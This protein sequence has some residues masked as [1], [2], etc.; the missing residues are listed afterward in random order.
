M[1]TLIDLP[2]LPAPDC[3]PGRRE[4]EIPECPAPDHRR[5]I[6]GYKRNGRT[7]ICPTVLEYVRAW[8]AV[9]AAKA[10]VRRARRQAARQASRPPRRRLGGEIEVLFDLA[11]ADDLIVA[12]VLAG[13]RYPR[14]ELTRGVYGLD[15]HTTAEIVRRMVNAHHSDRVIA[16]RVGLEIRSVTRYVRTLRAM[17]LVPPAG[18]RVVHLP[19]WDTGK[20][21]SAS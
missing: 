15:K 13:A 8:S 1:G 5:S 17:G 14:Q 19:N 7:C 16:E 12:A 10:R 9:E 4:A 3:A 20:W 2:R 21:A 18:Q 6:K 11:E